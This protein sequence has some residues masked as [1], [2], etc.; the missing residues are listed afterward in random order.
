MEDVDELV[1]LMVD[2]MMVPDGCTIR[3]AGMDR[4]ASVVKGCFMKLVHSHIEGRAEHGKSSFIR[5]QCRG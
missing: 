5:K 4:P 1:E 3:I 2:T